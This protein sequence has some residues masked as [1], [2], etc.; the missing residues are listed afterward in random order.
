MYYTLSY[1]K[2]ILSYNTIF[3]PY[4]LKNES[5]FLFCLVMSC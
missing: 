2:D 4:C 1:N 3:L 5:Q